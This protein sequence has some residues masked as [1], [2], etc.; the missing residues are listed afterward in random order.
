MKINNFPE[1]KEETEID[2]KDRMT[3]EKKTVGEYTER[4]K[5]LFNEYLKGINN[6]NERM[7]LYD[8]FRRK[9]IIFQDPKEN[10]EMAQSTIIYKRKLQTQKNSKKCFI[11]VKSLII[12]GLICLGLLLLR[13]FQ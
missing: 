8:Q 5:N 4:E 12:S 9:K 10:P 13:K 2:S 6:R 7:K 3:S 1:K 11:Y